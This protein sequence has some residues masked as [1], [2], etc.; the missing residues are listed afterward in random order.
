MSQTYDSQSFRDDSGLPSNW[1]NEAN[2]KG[3]NPELFHPVRGKDSR[4]A[5]AVCAGCIV[6]NECLHYALSNSIKVGIYGGK[7]ER[8]C[9]VLR[10]DK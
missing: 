8:Q 9:R 10:R 7:S 6:V 3:L 5:L 2:C 1:R 4:Q